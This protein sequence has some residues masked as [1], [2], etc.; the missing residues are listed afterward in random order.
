[1]SRASFTIVESLDVSGDT[2]GC[3]FFWI[4]KYALL[5]SSLVNFFFSSK[6]KILYDSDSD[7]FE[8]LLVWGLLY[9][10]LPLLLSVWINLKRDINWKIDRPFNFNNA[11]LARV[12]GN[13]NKNLP[14]K[15]NKIAKPISPIMIRNLRVFD[16]D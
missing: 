8:K 11:K 16:I 4:L 12:R 3:I 1:M 7:N 5:I 2:S 6:F 15:A 10:N 14:P 9:E 13:V